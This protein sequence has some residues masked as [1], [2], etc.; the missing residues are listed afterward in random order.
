[1]KWK[2]EL[3]LLY[4]SHIVVGRPFHG[5]ILD[6][7]GMDIYELVERIKDEARYPGSLLKNVIPRSL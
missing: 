6:D 3:T 4:G 5:S 2:E 1:M 7:P